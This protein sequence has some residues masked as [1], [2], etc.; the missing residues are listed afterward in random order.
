MVEL[1]SEK[2]LIEKSGYTSQ[3][4]LNFRN[5]RKAGKYEYPPILEEGKHFMKFGGGVAYTKLGVRVVMQRV[6]KKT[7][8]E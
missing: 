7:G 4:L 5:G 8:C 2:E 1:L 3:Q 6:Q